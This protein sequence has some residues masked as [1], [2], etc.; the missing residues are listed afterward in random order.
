[1]GSCSGN[2]GGDDSGCGC[3]T[4]SACSTAS[5]VI[6]Q[7]IA[8][9]AEKLACLLVQTTEFQTFMRSA[10]VVRMDRDVNGLVNRIN[11]YPAFESDEAPVTA[12][13]LQE[14]LEGMP[15]VQSYRRSE[16]TIRAIFGSVD[17]TISTLAGI[18]FAANAKSAGCGS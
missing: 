13:V 4:G 1:M 11:G 8:N 2:C 17:E 12:E 14:Q 16:S 18:P 7:S 5:Q 10:Q 15:V 3:G 6:D 9:A